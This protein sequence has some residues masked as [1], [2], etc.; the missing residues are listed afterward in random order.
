[1]QRIL[2][3]RLALKLGKHWDSKLPESDLVKHFQCCPPLSSIWSVNLLSVVQPPKGSTSLAVA[4]FSGSGKT[5]PHSSA[6]T[7]QS[8]TQQ[9]LIPVS[10]IHYPT[11]VTHNLKPDTGP[12]EGIGLGLCYVFRV[13]FRVMFQSYVTCLS[14]VVTEDFRLVVSKHK[15]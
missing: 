9:S 4:V 3:E 11:V 10:T 2:L 14:Y 7:N 8:N 12:H 13:V 6:P 1:M 5:I 15:I